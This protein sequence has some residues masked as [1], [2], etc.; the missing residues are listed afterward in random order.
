[1]SPITAQCCPGQSK[2]DNSNYKLLTNFRSVAVC[3]KL[4]MDLVTEG[5]KEVIFGGL[6]GLA[7]GYVSKKL[8]SHLAGAVITSGFVVFRAAVY[9]GQYSAT[10]SPLARDDHSFTE[11]LKRKA[12]KETFSIAKRL[13]DFSQ[14]NLLIFGGYLG[15]YM[16]SS[17]K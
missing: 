1:M 14:Q 17:A 10:W 5:G 16:M 11:H 9:D 6:A 4:I 12:R 8:G 7:A 3:Y 2:L 15:A 13:E